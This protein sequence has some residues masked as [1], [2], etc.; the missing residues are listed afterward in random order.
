MNTVGS[1]SITAS[2]AAVPNTG[3]Y[4]TTITYVDGTL[5]VTAKPSTGGGGYVP[6]NPGGSTITVPV[7]GD[8][9]TVRVSASVSGTTATVSK[10]DTTQIVNVIGDNGQAS[11]V[12]IDFTGLGKTID[13]V[14]LPTAAIKDI[15][16]KA[17]NEEVRGLTVKLP[18]VE[19][20]FDAKALSAIQ[21][22]ASN[23]I[24]LTVTPAKPADLNSRQKE[25]VGS[26]QCHEF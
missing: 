26:A 2:G 4:N 1:Y 19:I 16:A 3:N 14:K 10:I 7:S 15:A 8:K 13:T 6:S 22:Q 12:E 9:S 21:A 23:Q 20:S 11:M 24:T 17:Q 18:E 25:A 5:S